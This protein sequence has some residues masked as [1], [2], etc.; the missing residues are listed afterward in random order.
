MTNVLSGNFR[1]ARNGD[2]NG[3]DNDFALGD[4]ANDV[5]CSVLGMLQGDSDLAA[6]TMLLAVAW[7]VHDDPTF[8]KAEQISAM[9]MQATTEALDAFHNPPPLIV[10]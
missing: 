8:G 4:V 7:L 10:T 3:A 1:D 5:L 6:R 2:A 9:L